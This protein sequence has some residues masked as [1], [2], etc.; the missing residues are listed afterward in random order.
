VP[1]YSEMDA[2]VGWHAVP[3]RELA[4]VGH[5]LLHAHHAEFGGSPDLAEIERSVYAEARWRW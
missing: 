5:N 1:A 3:R 4:V 2:R